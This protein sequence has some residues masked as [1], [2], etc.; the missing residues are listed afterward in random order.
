MQQGS[1]QVIDKRYV[2]GHSRVGY[3]KPRAPYANHV[4]LAWEICPKYHQDSVPLQ[5]LMEVFGQYD[6]FQH[7]LVSNYG[8]RGTYER[9][10]SQFG[11]GAL[12]EVRPVMSQYADTGL[13]GFYFI[14]GHGPN[15]EEGHYFMQRLQVEFIKYSMRLEK[16][17]VDSGKNLLKS[18]LLM[19]VDSAKQSSDVLGHQLLFAGR[20]IPLEDLYTRIDNLSVQQVSDTINHYYYDRSLCWPRGGSTTSSPSS[21]TAAAPCTAGGTRAMDHGPC[22][23]SSSSTT[24]AAPC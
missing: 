12:E 24:A 20:P 1:D 11:C 21:T 4:S 13:M 3:G 17:Q 6:R 22:H 15:H 7:D 18:K 10:A 5:L 8:I 19:Q 2:G 16:A 23:R 14:H 9:N